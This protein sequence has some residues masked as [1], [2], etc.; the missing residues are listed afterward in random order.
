MARVF[1]AVLFLHVSVVWAQRPRNHP[2]REAIAKCQSAK[3]LSEVAKNVEEYVQA[4]PKDERSGEALWDLGRAWYRLKAFD[5][6][7]RILRRLTEGWPS[8]AGFGWL[9]L[10]NVYREQGKGK[11]QALREALQKALAASPRDTHL[12]IMDADNTRN[13]ASRWLG[14]LLEADGAWKEARAVY[15]DW[16]PTSWCGNEV[17]AFT[18]ERAAAI[19]RCRFH[20]GEQDQ[21][22][23]ELWR[24]VTR[25]DTLITGS[26]RTAYALI[27]LEHAA[28]AGKLDEA[29]KKIGALDEED[30]RQVYLVPLR[31]YEAHARKDAAALFQAAE[32][33]EDRWT[34]TGMDCFG[35]YGIPDEFPTAARL[36]SGLGAPTVEL[37]TR[38]IGRANRRAIVLAA[39]SRR[40]ELLAPLRQARQ[41]PGTFDEWLLKEA[42]ATLEEKRDYWKGG[43]GR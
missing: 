38:E 25:K 2:F 33:I 32:A 15:E 19:A 16:K 41:R 31:L 23:A 42:I 29:R 3:A 26:P 10:A 21:A 1:L 27:Y 11:E 6:A 36:L 9:G 17:E 13:I 18:D 35:F 28:L 20:L 12:S 37:L 34:K 43:V 40:E 5:E 22:V 24:L 8:H 39:L 4:F 14:S 7:E 30:H